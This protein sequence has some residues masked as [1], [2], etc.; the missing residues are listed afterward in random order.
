MTNSVHCPDGDSRNALVVEDDSFSGALLASLVSD[1]GFEV[2]RAVTAREA[3][4]IAGE[5]DVDLA[6]IDLDLGEGPNG[7]EV[8]R[9]VRDQCPWAAIVIISVHRSIS[10]LDPRADLPDGHFTFVSKSDLRSAHDIETAI[11][12]AIADR[13]PNAAPTGRD[14]LTAD[15]AGLLRMIAAGLTNEQIA[16][17]RS[18]TPRSVE[19]LV[20]RLYKALALPTAPGMNPRVEATRLYLGAKV[21][22]R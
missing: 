6:L 7:I 15:Q 18:C 4:D 2:E 11:S 10:M 21:E 19:R 22:S 17:E 12:A 13:P 1:L 16:L 20:A 5:F 3:I 9:A 14:D 8:A